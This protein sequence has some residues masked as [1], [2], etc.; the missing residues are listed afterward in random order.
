M[1][2]CF[3]WRFHQSSSCQDFWACETECWL[4]AN[5]TNDSK[6]DSYAI[7]SATYILFNDLS[8][9]T[10]WFLPLALS[11]D[12]FFSSDAKILL[13]LV[14]LQKALNNDL[15]PNW[16]DKLEMFEERPFAAASIGQVHLA[17]MKDGREVAMKIQVRIK[18]CDTASSCCQHS[19]KLACIQETHNLII[20]WM[21]FLTEEHVSQLSHAF[22]E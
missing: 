10:L 3:R 9:I 6:T 11:K 19:L 8:C 21:R 2:L 7:S 20:R 16:R 14:C 1:F 4:H 12:F 18:T 15:G 17:R 22:T 13:A 5:Q